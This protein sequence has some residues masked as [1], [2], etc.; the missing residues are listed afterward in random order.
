MSEVN[1]RR[2]FVVVHLQALT[3]VTILE[4]IFYPSIAETIHGLVGGQGGAGSSIGYFRDT[5]VLGGA[6]V[7]VAAASLLLWV[8]A[9]ANR[10]GIGAT[11]AWALNVVMLVASSLWYFHA[12][13]AASDYRG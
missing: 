11:M 5:Y 12:I 9:R 6:I 7:F 8:L 4:V 13:R 3:V 2:G 10:P 1:A